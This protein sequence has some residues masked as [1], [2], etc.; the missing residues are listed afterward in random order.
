LIRTVGI[1]NGILFTALAYA[2]VAG[3]AQVGILVEEIA[4]VK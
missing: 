2:N 1:P 3:L 4:V